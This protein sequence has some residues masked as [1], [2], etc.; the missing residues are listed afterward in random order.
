MSSL[1]DLSHPPPPEGQ[2]SPSPASS[3]HVS[4]VGGFAQNGKGGTSPP[5]WLAQRASLRPGSALAGLW[6]LLPVGGGL[7]D[8][9][10]A[11]RG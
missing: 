4:G 8:T 3:G 5:A 2:R 1:Q 7:A 11:N 6:S 9:P 10:R